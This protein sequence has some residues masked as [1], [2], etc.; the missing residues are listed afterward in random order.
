MKNL[1]L[2]KR[3]NGARVRAYYRTGESFSRLNTVEVERDK[4][5]RIFNFKCYGQV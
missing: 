4:S 3:A 2:L 1:K 5:L